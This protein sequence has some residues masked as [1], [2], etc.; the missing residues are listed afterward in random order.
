LALF[1]GSSQAITTQRHHHH[2]HRREYV[3][4]RFL[5][6]EK[7]ADGYGVGESMNTTITINGPASQETYKF[8]QQNQGVRFLD[9]RKF[10][11]GYG[12]G[13]SMNSTIT[14][15]GPASQETYK[16]AQQGN[17]FAEGFGDREYMGET[18]RSTGPER[19][20]TTNYVQ[21]GDPVSWQGPGIAFPPVP[22]TP[23]FVNVAAA[24]ASNVNKK[25]ADGKEAIIDA[26]DSEKF[27][28]EAT[29][30]AQT[31][32]PYAST[33]VQLEDPVSWQG[34]GIAFPP[35]PPTPGFVAVAAATAA[36]VNKKGADGKEAI[37]DAQDSE[38]FADDATEKAQTR[39]PYASTLVQL[40]DPV[41]WQGPG[42][43]FPP[44]PP[45]PGFVNVAAATASN[46]NKKGADGKEAI[47]DAQDSEKFAD[48]AT[49]KA[50]T[51]LPYASTLLQMRDDDPTKMETIEE[52]NVPLDFHFVHISNEY[53]ELIRLE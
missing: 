25:G 34:P 47:I 46:V 11:E 41:S 19:F 23:G 8:A 26:Q 44:V 35:V 48:E 33:L 5:D 22:P 53:G 40:D 9:E 43:K 7:F 17:Q 20:I 42:V 15:N 32:L 29:E 2:P 21:L 36:N 24:T 30:K 6:A 14:I 38:Q 28:D 4:V 37:I 39:L 45:T 18:I 16:F 3:G 49:D 13:E 27:A 12:V 51:R 52:S 50:Q 10:A 31:R 1:L